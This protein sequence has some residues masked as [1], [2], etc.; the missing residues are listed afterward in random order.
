MR[1]FLGRLDGEHRGAV[2]ALRVR[3]RTNITIHPSPP[4]L[5]ALYT[6]KTEQRSSLAA[7]LVRTRMEFEAGFAIAVAVTTTS[8]VLD[9][10]RALVGL[11][12]GA[13]SQYL[14]YSTFVI[15]VE[16]VIIA[17]LR[18]IVRSMSFRRPATAHAIEPQ[19]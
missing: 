10:P 8:I 14:P 17:S 2:G 13:I 5:P 18:E 6:L 11:A 4:L 16:S 12:F 15:P 19:R 3:L 1:V 7:P 9:W